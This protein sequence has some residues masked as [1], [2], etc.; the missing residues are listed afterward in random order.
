M[1]LQPA[2]G[3]RFTSMAWRNVAALPLGGTLALSL[4]VNLAW[5]PVPLDWALMSIILAFVPIWAA[6]LLFCFWCASP[7]RLWT[8]LALIGFA[9]LGFN[10]VQLH[11]S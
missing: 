9:S 10:L 8:S 1:A 4:A 3:T 11:A 6:I 2:S 7:S 5:L